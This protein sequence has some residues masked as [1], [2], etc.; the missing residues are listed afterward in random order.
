MR[1]VAS[2]KK[3]IILTGIGLIVSCISIL[4]THAGTSAVSDL[5]ID[6]IYA[7]Y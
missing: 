1:F 7:V 6:P 5:L 2:S 4:F 3:V